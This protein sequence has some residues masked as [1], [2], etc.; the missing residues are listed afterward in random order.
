MR[1]EIVEENDF[2]PCTAISIYLEGHGLLARDTFV[3]SGWRKKPDALREG[4]LACLH[5]AGYLLG[6]ELDEVAHK[7]NSTVDIVS[8][9]TY[10]ITVKGNAPSMYFRR[11]PCHDIRGGLYR[12]LNGEE[13]GEYEFKAD[14]EPEAEMERRTNP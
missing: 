14:A 6:S 12:Q 7:F 4:L 11:I 13:A 5:R 10:K 3:G 1:V 8:N 2:I 9:D